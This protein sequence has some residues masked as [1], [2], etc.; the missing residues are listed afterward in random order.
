[1]N[2]YDNPFHVDNVYGHALTLL[3]NASYDS[4]GVHLDIGCS[5]ARIAEHIRD[6]LNRVYCGFD[7]DESALRDLTERGFESARIDLSQ[8]AHIL[9]VIKSVVGDRKIASISMLDTLEHLTNPEAVISVLREMALINQ[10]PVVVSVPNFAHRDVGFKLAFGKWDYTEKGILDQTH[11]RIFTNQNFSKL[12]FDSGMHEVKRMD[13]EIELSDQH[14]PEY[15]P[16]LASS[17]PLHNFLYGLRDGIDE[18][19]STNQF[20][21]LYL[22]GPVPKPSAALPKAPRPFLSVVTRT[23]GRRLDTLRDVLLC[24]SAQTCEDFEVIVVGHKLPADKKLL[25]ERVIE[26]CFEGFRGQV[27]LLSVDKGNRTEPLNAGFGDAKGQYIAIL[28]DDDIVLANWVEAFKA[29][30][31]KYPGRVLRSS[32][33]AQKWEPVQPLHSTGTV[34]AVGG[35]E[36]RYPSHFDYFNH[37]IEN[38]TPPVS[39]AFPAD[40]FHHLGIK[41][42]ASLS[43]TEDWDFFM[44]TASVCGVGSSAEITSI[45]RQWHTGESSYTIHSSTEWM[46]NHHVI[47][48]KLDQ[49]PILLDVGSSTRIRNLVSFWLSNQPNANPGNIGLDRLP[50]PELEHEAYKDAMRL[51]IHQRLHSRAWRFTAPIR[52]GAALLGRK[53]SFPMLWSMDAPALEELNNAIQNST[54][55]RV[56]R[57]IKSLV[58]KVKP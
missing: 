44:R 11:F 6:D 35:M 10:C 22:P 17:T 57:K 12:M 39:L 34:R 54:S 27:R 49:F 24:L 55:M 38:A 50:H 30:A 37:L 5:Y 41:F 4:E 29:M 31:V 56:V 14:F 2:I 42:D 45:Y 15:H 21:R 36:K 52:L 26:D 8:P 32:T 48:R 43:T 25:V 51:M 33:V 19:A 18:F 13:V 47:W 3:K 28:D 1:M 46:A 9:D 16:A 58:R 23:Q 53:Q 40:C 20:V 7:I